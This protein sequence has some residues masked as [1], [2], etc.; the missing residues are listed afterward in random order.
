MMMGTALRAFAHP[1]DFLQRLGFP[2]TQGRSGLSTRISHH[3]LL[4]QRKGLND[5][6]LSEKP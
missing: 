6:A 2:M 1:T 5:A 4:R 3:D